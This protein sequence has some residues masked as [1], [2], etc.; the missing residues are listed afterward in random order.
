MDEHIKKVINKNIA[1]ATTV[2]LE[3]PA[4]EYDEFCKTHT[5]EITDE[6]FRLIDNMIMKPKYKI[7]LEIQK[8]HIRTDYEQFKSLKLHDQ[9]GRSSDSL[10]SIC[11]MI[12]R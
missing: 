10:W 6:I 8:N 3:N 7:Q 11:I 5:K 9:V 1:I 12:C 4:T 2:S